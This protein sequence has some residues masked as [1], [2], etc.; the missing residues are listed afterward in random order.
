MAATRAVISRHQ[1]AAALG[2][3]LWMQHTDIDERGPPLAIVDVEVVLVDGD[4]QA[5]LLL[6][7]L[8]RSFTVGC[9]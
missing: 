3:Q 5:L 2:G 4:P 9:L 6:V 1:N 7:G 8:R